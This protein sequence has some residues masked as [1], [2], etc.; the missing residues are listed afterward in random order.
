MVLKILKE[1]TEYFRK[2]ESLQKYLIDNEIE[3]H[4]TM[5]NGI[6]FS[7]NDKFYKYHQ[8]GGNVPESLPPFEEGRYVECDQN[9]NVDYYQ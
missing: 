7:T 1:N 4:Q 2:F 9:G 3:L 6:I 8:E 5:H